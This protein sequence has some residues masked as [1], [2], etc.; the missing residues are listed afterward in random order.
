M[1]GYT[2]DHEQTHAVHSHLISITPEHCIHVQSHRF[3]LNVILSLTSAGRC[4]SDKE[5]EFINCVKSDVYAIRLC[6]K[7]ADV[8]SVNIKNG[9]PYLYQLLHSV[10]RF[11]R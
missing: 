5:Y 3:S 4:V 11:S 2:S 8:Y 10:V 7:G 1:S 6:D 9:S